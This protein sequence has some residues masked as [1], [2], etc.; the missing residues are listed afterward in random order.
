MN[1]QNDYPVKGYR[2]ETG[3]EEGSEC[4]GGYGEPQL[5]ERPGKV[6]LEAGT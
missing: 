1:N 3:K 2:G 6:L 5:T 4:W